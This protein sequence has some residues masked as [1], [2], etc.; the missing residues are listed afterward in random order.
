MFFLYTSGT[1]EWLKGCLSKVFCLAFLFILAMF[2][3]T[4]IQGL[5]EPNLH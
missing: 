2:G 3:D 4:Y 5:L 1:T